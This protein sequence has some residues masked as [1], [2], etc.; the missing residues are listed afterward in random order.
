MFKT[1][2][3]LDNWKSKY[4]YKDETPIET[5]KRVAKAL[6]SV[7]KNPEEWEKK[8]LHVLL[9]YDNNAELPTGLK[10]T[11]G[12]RITANIG[13]DY[14][15]ATLLNCFVNGPVTDATISYTRKTENNQV[16]YP[17]Q[18]KSDE[19]PDDLVNIFLT[20]LEQAKTLASEGGYGINFD[21]I[22]PRG[23]LIKGIGIRHPGVVAYMQIWDAVSECIVKGDNDGYQDL[24]KNHLNTE[25]TE[26]L[27]KAV[28]K[29]A[30]KGAMLGCLSIH[31][32]DIEEFIRAKQTSGKLTKFNIS[33]AV[34]DR[35]I[36]SVINDSFYD[37]T[38]NNKIV[39]RIKAR[40]LYNLIMESTYNR[41]EPGILFVDN[42][43]RNNPIAYLGKVNAC[44]PCGEIGGLASI[45]TT[46]LLGSINL[47]QYVSL[48][49]KFNFK[50]YEEDIKV[51]VRMLDN[52]NDIT[53]SCLPSYDWVT[54]NLRQFGMGIHGL[55]STLIMMGIPYNSKEAIEFAKKICEL[56]ENLTWQASVLLAKEKGTFPVYDKKQFEDTEY[57]RSDRLWNETKEMIKK[58]GVRNAKTTTAPP[59]GNT[60]VVTDN[61]SN[62]I[63]PV[64]DLEYERKVIC[65]QWPDGMTTDNVKKILK[66]RKEKDFICW[67][68][69]YDGKEYY[70]EPHNRGLC[71]INVVRDYGYQWVLDNFPKQD[72]SKYLITTKKLEVKDHINIQAVV[73]YYC[74][75][76]VSKTCNIPEKYPF[77]DFKDLYIEAWKRGLNGFTTYRD[78]S[79]ES[80]LESID[81]AEKKKEII[82]KDIKLPSTLLNGPESIIK[83]EGMKFY[84]HFSYLPDDKAM[85]FPIVIWIYTNSKGETVACNKA[86]RELHKLAINCGIPAKYVD[87]TMEKAK[88]D[89]PHN[90]L[91]RMISLCL[92]HNIPR[93]D[94]YSTLF[95]IEGDNISSL[96][97]AVRK[98]IGNT[99]EEGTRMKIKCE[100]CGSDNI[101]FE[102]NCIRC[103]EPGCNWTACLG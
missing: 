96:L 69:H 45:T 91:G 37:L 35:F 74:N 5:F 21:F 65:S 52:V 62:G 9:N 88:Q 67:R 77:K 43:H 83:R 15:K 33:V 12:G 24:I 41:A 30:R 34:D 103:L 73:Q 75:Q 86:A 25:Q 39:K 59:L 10:C 4:R 85:K 57:F 29:M 94:I 95:G 90:K 54:K 31:H 20:I 80:V 19:S 48:E 70:Y 6:A 17:V 16:K 47:T 64:F 3:A 87:E 89:M 2:M 44:N 8:F 27:T 93:Q 66:E 38:F 11:P 36:E 100:G 78:G 99:I 51:F 76:S 81:R 61:A 22:R 49:R 18:L 82:K 72:H 26:E 14:K 97:G 23:S 28:K 60:S 63:E 42:M 53:S 79:M 46:C 1:T 13:T 40:E 68:G 102:S 50:Q 58:Y 84:L 55:G 92:R 56:K 101:R 32:P 7:E 71:E 98:F